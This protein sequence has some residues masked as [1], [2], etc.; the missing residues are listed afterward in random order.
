MDSPRSAN[1]LLANL[2]PGDFELIESHLRAIELVR[3]IV[4]AQAGDD[5]EDVYFPH[6]GIISLVVRLIGGE[7]T[8]V[9]MVGRDSLF[10]ASAAL[11]S[12]AALATAVVQ[13][14]GMCS[15]LPVTRLSE[16]ADRSKTLRTT[17]VRHEQ[18]I[19][20]QARQAAACIAVHPAAARLARWLLRARDVAG[21]DHLHFSRDYL[22]QMLGVQRNAVALVA[23]PLQ[24][25]G[26]ISVSRGQVQI[27]DVAGLRATA[28]ECYAAVRDELDHLKRSA[29]H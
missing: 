29:L 12:P 19:F 25:K 20:V 10:G 4:L 23:G 22:G 24:D 16:A 26:L 6:S 9:A 2:S 13:S 27:V 3:E 28:C 15:A 11:G 18:A 21:G 7:T 1:R 17:L 8:E 14:P 5:L